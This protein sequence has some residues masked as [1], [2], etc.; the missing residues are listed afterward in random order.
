MFVV[1]FDVV[2]QF[3][4]N[5]F[6]SSQQHHGVFFEEEGVV[7]IGVSGTHGPFVDDDALGLPDFEDGHAGDWAVGVFEGRA[8]DDVVGAHH[9][10]KVGVGEV[11][12]DFLH[13][14][15]DVVGDADFGQEHVHLSRHP[16]GHGV[17][18]ES[19]LNAVLPVSYTHLTLPTIYSV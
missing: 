10:D 4:A 3:F 7:D 9:D 17:D 2:P 16:A 18:G 14:Q 15:D 12:V 1:I 19:D 8:V 5:I 13:F 6:T 11:F